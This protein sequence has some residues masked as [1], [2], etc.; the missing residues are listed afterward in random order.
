MGA[1]GQEQVNPL[2][3][4]PI[5]IGQPNIYYLYTGYGH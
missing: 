4:L 1:L 3:E 2:S 5:E